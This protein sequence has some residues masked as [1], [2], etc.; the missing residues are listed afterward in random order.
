VTRRRGQLVP[1]RREGVHLGEMSDE[2]LVAACATGDRTARAALFERH[3][4]GV[5]RFVARMTAADAAAVDDLVQTTFL[6]A[7]EAAARFRGASQVRSWL[8]GIALNVVRGYARGEIR[9]KTALAAVDAPAIE[10][11]TAPA[12]LDQRRQLARLE[13][14]IGQ[15]RHDLRAVFVLVDVEGMRGVDAAAAL[16]VPEGTVWRR[17]HEARMALRAALEGSR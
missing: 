7:F 1:L 16:A 12:R 17:L 11:A 9:R 4:D 10:P 14:A 6:R 13:A 15:L 8:F 2:A 3:L 5:H